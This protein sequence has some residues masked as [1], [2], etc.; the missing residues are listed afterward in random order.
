VTSPPTPL[1]ELHIRAALGQNG[2]AY[3]ARLE[4]EH[5]AKPLEGIVS[6]TVR[7]AIV[8]AVVAALDELRWSSA[9][10]IFVPA[11]EDEASVRDM[12]DQGEP[13]RAAARHRF[14]VRFAWPGEVERELRTKARELAGKWERPEG[15]EP[16]EQ[17]WRKE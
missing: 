8:E 10:T 7:D 2:A 17:T 13:K 14:T 16:V 4:S 12:L 1:V 11:R 5:H 6:G 15:E 3:A 9:V